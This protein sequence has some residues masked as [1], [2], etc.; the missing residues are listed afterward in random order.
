M[1]HEEAIP[2]LRSASHY[3]GIIIDLTDASVNTEVLSTLIGL[4]LNSVKSVRGGLVINAGLYLPWNTKKIKQLKDAVE[5]LC[6][7]TPGYKYYIYTTIIPSFNGERAYITMAHSSR[8]MQDPELLESIPA[9]IRRGTRNLPNSLIDV[10][11][12]T[13]SP[14]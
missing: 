7:I 2:F 1:V 5:K 8:F 13:F 6:V 11:A 14:F 10:N 9:W 3:N 12:Q 4:A